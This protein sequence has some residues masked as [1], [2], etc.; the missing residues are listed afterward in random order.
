MI[1]RS[2][3][4]ISLILTVIYLNQYHIIMIPSK[5]QH[6]TINQQLKAA[7]IT[8]PKI[9]IAIIALINTEGGFECKE[10]SSYGKTS[11]SR[12][13]KIFGARL[14]QYS[15]VQLDTLKKNDIEFYE[16]IYAGRYGN[17]QYG[18]AYK[19]RGR[20]FNQLTFKSAYE[21]Y[22]RLT[23]L[24]LV[25]QPELLNKPENALKVMAAYF[26]DNHGIGQSTG[27]LKRKFNVNNWDELIKQQDYN[28]LICQMNAGWGTNI[29]GSIFP[30]KLAKIDAISFKL[31]Q[32]EA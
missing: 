3:L 22:S 12:L 21:K 20:G 27:H 16:V 29:T 15:D 17:S 1:K 19:Y 6:N 25:N 9:R 18:D 10:E 4:I 26:I 24:D 2:L 14:S 7:G 8:N 5:E 28:R 30:E 13:R 11:T 23:G 32:Y 31:T